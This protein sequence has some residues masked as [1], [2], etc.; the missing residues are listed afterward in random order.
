[1][2][3]NISERMTATGAYDAQNRLKTVE[4]LTGTT[5]AQTSTVTYDTL[6]NVVT[7]SSIT[8]TYNYTQI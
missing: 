1:V 4:R 8:G 2:N 3:Q 6:G 5:V 7:K